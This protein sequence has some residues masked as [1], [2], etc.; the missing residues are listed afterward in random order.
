MG[1][2]LLWVGVKEV[3]KIIVEH[4]GIRDCISETGA[5]AVARLLFFHKYTSSFT[6]FIT[7]KVA[8]GRNKTLLLILV[9]VRGSR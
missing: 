5:S 3:V 9:G 2:Y 1:C 6:A 7:Y 4:F 8:C